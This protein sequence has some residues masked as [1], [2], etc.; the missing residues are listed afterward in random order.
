LPRRLRAPDSAAAPPSAR[1]CR[2]AS[3]RQT[4]P[5]RLRAPDSA[6]ALPSARLCRGASERQA[7]PRRPRTPDS[8]AA[9]PSARRCRDASERQTLPRRLRTPDSA[10]ALPSA[11]PPPWPLPSA[12]R[13]RSAPASAGALRTLGGLGGHF[14]APHLYRRALV[15]G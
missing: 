5:R 10:A 9:L 13:P 8:A 3:E 12:R 11:S 6:A 1:L 7:L 14:G 4:L 15:R 2:G